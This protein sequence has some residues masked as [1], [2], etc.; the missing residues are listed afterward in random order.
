MRLFYVIAIN[1]F[2][3]RIMTYFM[4]KLFMKNLVV[5]IITLINLALTNMTMKN[6]AMKTINTMIISLV[7]LLMPSFAFAASDGMHEELSSILLSMFCLVLSAQVLGWLMSRFG[8]PR[9]IG[10]VLAGVLVGPSLLGLVHVNVTLQALA[11]F[12]AI[13]LMFAVG[14]ENKIRDLLV[15][16]KEAIIVAILGIALPML[17]GYVFGFMHDLSQI[18]SIFIGTSMVATSVGITAQELNDL[19]VINSKYARIILGAAVIDDIL[20]LAI[21]GVVSGMANGEEITIIGVSTTLAISLGF[22]IAVLLVGVPLINRIQSRLSPKKISGGFGLIISLSLGFAALSSIAGLAPIIGAFL[23][24][25]VL[26]EVSEN[27]DF[28]DKVHAL[29]SFLAPVFFAMVGVQ[30][31]LALLANREVLFNGAV[32]TL[33]AIVGKWLGGLAIAPQQGFIIAN[34]VGVGMVPR[35]EVGLI[36]VGIGLTT[37]LIDN[38]LFAEIVVMIIAT[39]ILA[40]IVLRL[41]IKGSDHPTNQ[42]R[43]KE[44]E[45]LGTSDGKGI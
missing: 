18:Q 29:E 45:A 4:R 15:V 25:M 13:F 23:I 21:L 39:T 19:G 37:N 30:L 10:Q 8:Q 34:K 6:S 33:I 31:P 40:P 38:R 20:G 1:A 17:G 24:G 5:R 43:I 12:G 3:M 44:V 28:H 16:G 9:V 27:Y 41:L 7:C 26:A 11:E 36:V 32:L 14:L 22:V 35:G 42:L 2:S